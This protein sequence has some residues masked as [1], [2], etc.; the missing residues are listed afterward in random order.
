M[1]WSL[2]NDMDSEVKQNTV[3]TLARTL[4]VWVCFDTGVVPMQLLHDCP[5][6]CSSSLLCYSSSLESFLFSCVQIAS[7]NHK[8]CR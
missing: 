4:L 2:I 8:Y 6:G 1:L 5:S 3:M 7:A